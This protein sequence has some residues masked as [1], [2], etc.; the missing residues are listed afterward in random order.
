MR[1]QWNEAHVGLRTLML[2]RVR[3][4]AVCYALQE[5]VTDYAWMRVSGYRWAPH[6]GRCRPRTDDEQKSMC[7][8]LG[9]SSGKYWH[10]VQDIS[11]R[12][13]ER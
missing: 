13:R 1:H 4:C 6:V 3:V 11:K 10:V 2:D 12:R 7:A 9:I 8:A 5:R